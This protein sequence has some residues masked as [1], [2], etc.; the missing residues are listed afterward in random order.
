M[1]RKLTPDQLELKAEKDERL[2]RKRR[3][4]AA[5]TRLNE[6]I[7]ERMDL[8]PSILDYA[9]QLQG[10]FEKKYQVED[11]DGETKSTSES[12][13][14]IKRQGDSAHRQ[15]LGRKIDRQSYR[16]ELLPVMDLKTC[17][18]ELSPLRFT[19]AALKGL[20]S[21]GQRD[22]TRSVLGQL[23]EQQTGVQLTDD[24]GVGYFEAVGDVASH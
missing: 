19:P 4:Q 8:V 18:F 16:V 13:G 20:C 3:L 21:R 15:L 12:P 17:L 5:K 22:V 24:I 2:A 1:G 6:V 9:L 23:V 7:K 10:K 14:K 11:V